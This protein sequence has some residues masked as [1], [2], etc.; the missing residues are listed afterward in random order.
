MSVT[1]IGDAFIDIIVP[2]RDMEPGGTYHRDI[3]ARCGGTATTAVQIARLGEEAGFLGRVGSDA[4]GKYFKENLKRN[5]VKDMTV[6]DTDHRTGLCIAMTYPNGERSMVAD[7]GANNY[8]TGQDIESRLN[9][10]FKSEIIYLSGYSLAKMDTGE[11]LPI[12]KRCR[13]HDCQVWFNPGAPNIITDSIKYTVQQFFDVIILNLDEAK[14]LTERESIAEIKIALEKFANLAVI[15][16]GKEGCIVLRTGQQ[17]ISVGGTAVP[18]VFDTTGAGDA[19]AAG[20]IVGRL[21]QMSDIE[22]AQLAHQTAARF[23][24]EKAR[25]SQ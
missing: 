17:V 6:V 24:A 18:N 22:C 15:T 4:L 3:I 16:M 1:V 14:A 7:R 9:T 13:E 2:I 5:Q 19:F 11:T 10:I 25:P 23:L 20:F 21:R 12:L 8:L